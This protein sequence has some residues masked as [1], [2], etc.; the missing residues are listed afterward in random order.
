MTA[1]IFWQFG[2][3]TDTAKVSFFLNNHL[4]PHSILSYYTYVHISLGTVIFQIVYTLRD[5][6]K[7]FSIW[8]E[9]VYW[10]IICILN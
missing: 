8:Q 9:C 2:N 4:I 1:T 5:F 3:T 7:S 6:N 10:H